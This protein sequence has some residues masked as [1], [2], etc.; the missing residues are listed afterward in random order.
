MQFR[1][2]SL[3][4]QIAYL[5]FR[6]KPASDETRLGATDVNFYPTNAGGSFKSLVRT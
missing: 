4:A 2:S 1:T 6:R 3:P 5:M